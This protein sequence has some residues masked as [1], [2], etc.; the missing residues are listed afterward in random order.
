MTEYQKPIA[1]FFTH[2]VSLELWKQR[3]MFSREVQFFEA[4]AKQ[5]G[6]I[7][8]FTYGKDDARFQKHVGDRIKI[9]PK[10]LP[11]PNLLYGLL[12]PFLYWKDL[13]SVRLVRIH[14]MA[15]AIPALIAHSIFRKPL[16]VRCGYQWS[17]FSKREEAKHFK[18]FVIFLIERVAYRRAKTIIVTTNEDAQYIEKRYS[19]PAQK[20]HV[21]P[22]YVDT[23]LFQP[24]GKQKERNSICFVG[25]LEPQKNLLS[26]V[27]A[28]QDT[29]A[30][31]IF[32][33]EG[34][35]KNKLEQKAK[36]LG[37]PLSLYGK[38]PNGHLPEALNAC[39]IFIL[40]SLFEGNPKVLLE[41][42]S[43]GLP[44]IGTRVDGIQSILKDNVNGVLCATDS[45]SIH[46]TILDLLQ[47]P[48]KQQRLGIAARKTIL[49]TNTLSC[50]I[51]KEIE[52]LTG[53]SL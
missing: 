39:E 10:C 50:A 4:L 47:N 17:Q 29:G 16:L 34:S 22:N 25:R 19:L 26:L 12:F 15:G 6:E 24:L 48:E 9:F 33:G 27:E 43:C 45:Q 42:M 37:I 18:R 53:L 40:P 7:W 35:L 2:G 44:V 30:H 38:I 28:I 20:I 51:E 31:L 52:I 8:F 32:Y 21:I 11:V 1:V 13:R 23:D 49:S 3:G 36:S 14:Q 46:K 5:T 41:A